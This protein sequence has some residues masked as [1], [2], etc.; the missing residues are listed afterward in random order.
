MFEVKLW[1]IL[2]CGCQ[3]SYRKSGDQM[4]SGSGG[5]RPTYNARSLLEMED[6]DFDLPL[7]ELSKKYRSSS[8]NLLDCK[9]K[10][11]VLKVQKIANETSSLVGMRLAANTVHSIFLTGT[12]SQ[13]I[14]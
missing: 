9:E 13:R 5:N 12:H 8:N 4:E 1:L 11:G 14:K 10:N 3:N 7:S 2:F 6:D